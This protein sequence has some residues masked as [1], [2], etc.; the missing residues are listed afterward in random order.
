V[1][2][3]HEEIY[4]VRRHRHQK[5]A[6]FTIPLCAYCLQNHTRTLQ[7]RYPVPAVDPEA[8]QCP[9]RDEVKA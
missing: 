6:S 4:Q 1:N 7:V 5:W 9:C 3:I 8:C 2:L